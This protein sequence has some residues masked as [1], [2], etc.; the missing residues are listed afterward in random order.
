MQKRGGGEDSNG[1][2]NGECR[3]LCKDRPPL[4]AEVYLRVM[5]ITH[6]VSVVY[7]KPSGHHSCRESN[8]SNAMVGI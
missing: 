5:S 7:V 1:N 6:I 3:D 4:K 8:S 2:S